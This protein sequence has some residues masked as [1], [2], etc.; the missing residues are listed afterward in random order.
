MTENQLPAEIR[1]AA[2]TEPTFEVDAQAH[3]PPEA[4][5]V[6][7][8]AGER[9]AARPGASDASY[10]A[11]AAAEAAAQQADPSP[12]E[13]RVPPTPDPTVDL[14]E[15]AHVPPEAGVVP[16]GHRDPAS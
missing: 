12:A 9:A 13:L 6:A 4:A 16:G 7:L 10:E 2:T 11:L 1:G 5:I 15:G 8:T 14:G 3:V